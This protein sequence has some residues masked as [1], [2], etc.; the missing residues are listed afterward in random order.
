MTNEKQFK[1]V[2]YW[3]NPTNKQ[4][5]QQTNQ[6]KNM[7]SLTSLTVTY[8]V[9][10]KTRHRLVTIILSNLKPIFKILYCWKVLFNF[11]QTLRNVIHKRVARFF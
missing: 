1:T 2:F 9:P 11:L 5:N 3:S 8:T 4:T 7:T 10:Q 6:G